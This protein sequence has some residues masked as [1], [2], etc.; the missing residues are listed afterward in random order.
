MQAIQ[1]LELPNMIPMETQKQRK[2]HLLYGSGD[3]KM[4]GSGGERPSVSAR[5]SSELR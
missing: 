5:Q 4:D 3:V 2:L 1:K